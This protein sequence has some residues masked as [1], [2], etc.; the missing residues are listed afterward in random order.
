MNPVLWQ[1]AISSLSVSAAAVAFPDGLNLGRNGS[2]AYLCCAEAFG[3]G[4]QG[5][6][7]GILG[8]FDFLLGEKRGSP[9]LWKVGITCFSGFTGD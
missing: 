1:A 4:L 9:L 8:I 5:V 3:G 2:G 7:N 6:P